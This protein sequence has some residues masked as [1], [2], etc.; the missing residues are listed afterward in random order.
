MVKH[1]T[2]ITTIIIGLH[3]VVGAGCGVFGAGLADDVLMNL[4]PLV[5]IVTS[6]EEKKRKKRRMNQL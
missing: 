6:A 5:L 1:N 2:I 3:T 4:V